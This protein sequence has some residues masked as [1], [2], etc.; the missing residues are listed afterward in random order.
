MV[1]YCKD[2]GNDTTPSRRGAHNA[3]KHE[4]Y[5]VKDRVWH[6]AGML[7]SLDGEILCI[8]CLEG[9]LGRRLKPRDFTPAVVNDP[10]RPHHTPRL[11][12]RLTGTPENLQKP[13]EK[14]EKNPSKI[15]DLQNDKNGRA[16]RTVAG[17]FEVAC[18]GSDSQNLRETILTAEIGELGVVRNIRDLPPRAFVARLRASTGDFAPEGQRGFPSRI[19]WRHVRGPAVSAAQMSDYVENSDDLALRN[20]RQPTENDIK[21]KR[22]TA[23]AD[24]S[25]GINAVKR[26]DWHPVSPARPIADDLAI[27]AFLRRPPTV[28]NETVDKPKKLAA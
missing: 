8:G 12:S 22:S 10:A 2:C 25:A 21:G 28:S 15:K 4:Y 19:K 3:G 9:R 6:A 23:A 26:S 1:L 24:Y 11:R 20:P 14:L 13:A 27:P 7:S 17:A 16:N 5:M 18:Q